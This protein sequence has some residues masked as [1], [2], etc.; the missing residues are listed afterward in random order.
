[1]EYTLGIDIGT[2]STKAVAIN[3][4]G[5]TFAVH[6]V[7]YETSSP[8]QGYS[9]QNPEEIWHAVKACLLSIRER[10]GASP[11]AVG[12][13]SAM[14]SLVLLDQDARLLS[15]MLTWADSRSAEIASEL[16]SS[17]LG[18]SI[19]EETG[20]PI[21]AMS[22]LCKMIWFRQHEVSLFANTKHFVSIKE[23]IWFQLFGEFCVDYSIAS[24][25]GLFNISTLLWN[26]ESLALAG[27]TQEQ[28]S[29]PV[30]TDYTR[31]GLGLKENS[32]AAYSDV[33]FVIGASDGCLANLG[34]FATAPG[35][36]AVTI[37]TSGAVRV[38]S[39]HPIIDFDSMIFNYL[40]NSNSFICGGPINNG[41]SAVK[42]LLKSVF[43]KKELT[44]STYKQLFESI[45]TI[46]AGSDGLLFLPYLTGE[47]APLWN[48]E[49]CGT[50]FGLKSH[51]NQSHLSRAVLEGICFSLK[52]VLQVMEQ[53]GATIFQLN[54]SGGFVQ[55]EIW[56]QMLADVTGK[57]LVLAQTEDAS[58]IGAAYLAAEATN[59]EVYKAI[60]DFRS[61]SP[62]HKAQQAYQKIFALFKEL[63]QTTSPIMLKLDQLN[64]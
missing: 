58:A 6:Q 16:R 64:R 12:L 11:V 35:V 26:K 24:C 22:P 51:H 29:S 53:K 44:E 9:E 15:P 5:E 47:R 38:A 8:K 32:L 21:H 50:F 45:S 41:G 46:K 39:R 49:S 31:E 57:K 36:A 37:G 61:I 52:D 55:S 13:S 30:D 23:Y 63:Y 19:Y 28:L 2:G 60:G 34:S 43:G 27:I 3:E 7:Y 54:I 33:K 1:M 40:L 48:E 18:K 62:N 10:I 17:A 4:A 25:T 14:H 59:F 42:W 20:T 56:M